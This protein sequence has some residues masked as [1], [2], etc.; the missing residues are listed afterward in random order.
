M[1]SKEYMKSCEI[2]RTK[3]PPVWSFCLDWVTKLFEGWF[4]KKKCGQN[5]PVTVASS[6]KIFN[7]KPLF[8][9][10]KKSETIKN[11]EIELASLIALAGAFLLALVV[12][13]ILR[14]RVCQRRQLD[15]VS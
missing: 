4:P 1:P 5:T 9:T 12:V 3:P 8:G 15:Q 2:S 10:C 6:T 13:S 14:Q 7:L 11:S